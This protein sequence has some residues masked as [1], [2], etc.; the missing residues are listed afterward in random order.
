M[1]Y[2]KEKL[3]LKFDSVWTI[4]NEKF[5]SEVDAVLEDGCMKKMTACFNISKSFNN[6]EEF[7]I[8]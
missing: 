6:T 1:K 8:M 7:D 2:F 5:I 4:G 3:I